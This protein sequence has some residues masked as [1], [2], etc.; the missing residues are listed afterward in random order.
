MTASRIDWT[1][2]FLSTMTAEPFQA[3][4]GEIAARLADEVAAGK[5]PFLAMPYMDKLIADLGEMEPWIRSFEHMLVLGIGGSALGA[6]ALQKAFMPGQDLPGHK[7]PWLWIADNVDVLS[8]ETCLASLPA[9]KT[10]VVTI[11]K[12]GDTI[13]TLGWYFMV[14]RWLKEKLPD[15]WG[16]HML[17]VTDEHKG[18]LREEAGR[19]GA[20]TLAVPDNLGGRYS[21]LSAVGLVPAA[22]MGMDWR[23]LAA[24]ARTVAAPLVDAIKAGKL[25]AATLSAHP[26][27]QLACWA[28]ALMAKGYNELIFFCYIPQWAWYGDWFCQLWAESLGKQGLGSQPLRS[29]GVTDQHSVNQMY[30]DGPRNKGCLFVTGADAPKGPD[31]P[32]DL[33]DMFAYIQGRPFGDLLEAEGLGTRMA[34]VKSGAPLVALNMAG[35]TAESAG[36]LMILLEAATILTGWLMGVNP[37]DQPAVELGKRLAK[38]RLGAGGLAEEKKD[39][40]AFLS[41]KRTLGEF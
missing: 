26:S 34:L 6:R 13:E 38:A 16:G 19:M 20:K 22:F 5:L 7:G 8:L 18:Y 21:A 31:F 2:A 33:P 27:F 17:L 36:K 1:D 4:A 14:K 41:A 40:E 32:A 28:M 10:L 29:V 24:G 9:E 35:A 25:D 3:R 39:L 30:L 15:S 11:S 12:S 37:V 23:G